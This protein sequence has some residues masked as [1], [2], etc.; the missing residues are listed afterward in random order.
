MRYQFFAKKTAQFLPMLIFIMGTIVAA[1]P[2]PASAAAPHVSAFELI[3]KKWHFKRLFFNGTVHYKKNTATAVFRGK[4][5]QGRL[6][7]VE[8]KIICIIYPNFFNGKE[9]CTDFVKLSDTQYKTRRG[10]ILT[11]IE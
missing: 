9:V 7:V 1:Y 2:L 6:R 5:Y 10:A 4:T 3:G 11:L 8:D